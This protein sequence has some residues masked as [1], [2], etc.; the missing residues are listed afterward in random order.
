[1]VA[2]ICRWEMKCKFIFSIIFKGRGMEK[3][4]F[5]DRYVEDSPSKK[6]RFIPYGKN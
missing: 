5:I 3:I 2:N 4:E 6:I 1:M